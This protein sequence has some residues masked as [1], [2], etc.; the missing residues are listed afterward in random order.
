MIKKI[1]KFLSRIILGLFLLLPPLEALGASA[2]LPMADIGDFGTW[3]T[4]NNRQLLIGNMA[5]DIDEFQGSYITQLV[6]DYVPIEAKIGLMFMNAMS[7]VGDVLDSS[8][9]RFVIIFIIIA[10]AFWIVFETYNMMTSG[11]GDVMKLAQ[12]IVKKGAI[13]AI[14]IIVLRFGPAR[15]FMWIMG[16]IISVATVLSDLI[17]NAVSQ[18]AGV[19][20]P[21]TCGAIREYA[22]TH[23][24]DNNIMTGTNAA[25]LMCLPSRMSGFCYTAIAAGWEWIKAGI[26]NSAFTFAVGI[27]FIVMFISVAW[28]FMFMALGVIADLF[29]GV[30]MLPFTAIAETIGKTSYK[31]I[32]GDIFNQFLGLFKVENLQSQIQ[33]FI[34]AAIFFVSLSIVIAFCTAMMSGTISTNLSSN[35]PT[36]ENQG[37]WITLLVGA[38]TWYFANQAQSLAQKLGGSIND[39][40]GQQMK[41]DITKLWKNASGTAKKWWKIIRDKK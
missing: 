3:A 10:Y 40:I 25:D 16:P 34:N 7:F 8:L 17:L 14:W 1:S 38:L 21:D 12:D 37:F 22:V 24:S 2:N 31:G 15:I 26:G 41:G 39:S 35:V 19:S 11:K 4:E 9:V 29:L 20:L 30:L 33:R 13:I 18:S 36:I 28:K 5:R 23:I 6:D 32:A 27:V